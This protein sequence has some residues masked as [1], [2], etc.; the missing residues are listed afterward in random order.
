M[1]RIYYIYKVVDLQ[2]LKLESVEIIDQEAEYD[3]RLLANGYLDKWRAKDY[4][5]KLLAEDEYYSTF[6][7]QPLLIHENR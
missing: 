6:L 3:G 1:I 4:V 7:I 2:T 5:T